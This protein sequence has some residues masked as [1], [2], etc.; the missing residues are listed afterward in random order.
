MDI[1]DLRLLLSR[2]DREA[3][4]DEVVNRDDTQFLDNDLISL[5][6]SSLKIDNIP[7]GVFDLLS[8][9]IYLDL[10]TNNLFSL[11]NSIFHHLENLNYINLSQNKLK[12]L[13]RDIFGI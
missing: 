11:S 10:S 7:I 8:E 9:L 6:L 1:E 2:I 3:N 4:F 12:T 5:D 13:P